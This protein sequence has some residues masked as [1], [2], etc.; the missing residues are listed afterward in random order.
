MSNQSEADK[1]RE[2]EL[3]VKYNDHTITPAE[4]KEFGKLVTETVNQ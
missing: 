4:R 3:A 2:A 1:T